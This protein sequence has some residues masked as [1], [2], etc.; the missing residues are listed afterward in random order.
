MTTDIAIHVQNLNKC[1]HIYD[2]PRDRLRQF[3]LPRLQRLAGLPPKQYFRE[4]WALK[5]ISFEIKKGETVGIIGRNG[6]GKSTLLQMICGT[7]NPSSGSVQTYGRIAALLELGSGFNPEFTGRENVY[8]NAAVLGLSN[9]EIDKRFDDIVTFADIG[10]FIE[11]PVKTYSSGMMVR[12]AFAVIAHVDADILVIDEALAVGDAFFTQKCM[13]YLRNFMKTGTVLFVSHDTGAVVNLCSKAVLLD[14]GQIKASGTPKQVTELYLETLYESSQGD[15]QIDKT[16]HSVSNE[17]HTDLEYKDAREALINGST[18]R[19]DIEVFKFEPEKSGFG[20]DIAVI[21][22]VVLRSS[23]GAPLSWVVGGEDVILEIRCKAHEQILRPIVGFQFKDRL[24][25]VVFTD[26]TYLSYQFN[27]P[28]VDAGKDLIAKFEFRLPI[29]PTGDYSVT[30]ALA[31]GTQE[32]HVQHHWIHDALII[33]VHAS[34]VCQGLVG[35]P[36]K[37]ICL[38]IPRG[39]SNG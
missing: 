25:Q 14:R 35:I 1:Y 24:G 30:V 23:D 5:D 33:R 36:M 7:L 17:Y 19:N 39:S 20:T 12:L 28:T 26:N 29:L 8:M 37:A 21:S 38:Y 2:T 13:R 27:S 11:Q 4:F 18:L 16:D 15:I 6:S 32:N 22:S 9:E 3:V 31:E 34:S 10:D